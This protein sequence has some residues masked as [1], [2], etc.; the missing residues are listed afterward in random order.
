MSE[1]PTHNYDE[2]GGP[3][4]QEAELSCLAVALMSPKGAERLVQLLDPTDFYIPCHARIFA[5]IRE[6]LG[7]GQAVDPVTLS[8][9]LRNKSWFSE[10]GG[11]SFI[12]TLPLA[13]ALLGVSEYAGIVK[14]W[15]N[16]R[17]AL[18]IS[19]DMAA[20]RVGISEAAD[21][22]RRLTVGSPQR[23]EVFTAREL[24]D[25]V[26]PHVDWIIEKL[27]ARGVLT[28][29]G[30]KPKSGKT[31]F[32]F[33][34]AYAIQTGLPFMG[35]ATREAAVLYITEQNKTTI[36]PKLAEYGLLDSADVHIMF[37]R[38]MLGL[39]WPEIISKAATVCEERGIDVVIID[40]VND[41]CRLEDSFSDTEWID[42]LD[43]LQALAQHGGRA[44]LAS[45]HAKKE[46][47]SLVDMFR[48]SNA[49]VG[50]ADIVL[51][52]WRDGTGE[53]TTRTV[54]G[55]SRL[56]NGFDERTRIVREGCEYMTTGTVREMELE[57]KLTE[58]LSILPGERAAALTRQEIA[59]LL[60]VSTGTVTTYIT[61][62][63]AAGKVLC[64]TRPGQGNTRVYWA[65]GGDA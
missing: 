28:I 20:G 49:I 7:G 53:E 5:G 23:L 63:I 65:A 10:A 22:L 11:A 45:F 40:T 50:K 25:H 15:A 64:E 42:A 51:G 31:T 57:A 44:V 48:G 4:S 3:Y 29:I 55:M 18:Q 19:D 21:K 2:G 56:D 61:K 46:A 24:R 60:D 13:S 36:R 62:L 32:L 39:P 12:H 33:G 16:K 38:Q 54:E 30:G 47:A 34:A 6:M 27:L 14:S 17:R 1:S 58:Y 43:P 41:L 8:E 37:P 59:A 35:L 52:L 9:F 26:S